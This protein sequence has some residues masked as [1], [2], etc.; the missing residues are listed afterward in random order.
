MNSN[1]L[2]SFGYGGVN[3]YCTLYYPSVVLSGYKLRGLLTT[4]ESIPQ[5]LLAINSHAMVMVLS[6]VIAVLTAMVI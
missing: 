5:A 1:I 3:A 6:M 2:Y 4:Y